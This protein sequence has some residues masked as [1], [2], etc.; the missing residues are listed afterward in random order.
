MFKAVIEH[1]QTISKGWEE[2]E[3]AITGIKEEE[4]M[5][6]AAQIFSECHAG[7]GL[8]KR[9]L[10]LEGDSIGIQMVG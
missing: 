3:V 2:R 9:G 7:E 10:N 6:S 1:V 5:E 8:E 4:D